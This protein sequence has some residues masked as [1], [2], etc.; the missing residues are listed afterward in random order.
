[1][2]CNLDRPLFEFRY[3]RAGRLLSATL[4]SWCV[5]STWSIQ[6]LWWHQSSFPRV[7]AYHRLWN[8]HWRIRGSSLLCLPG[9]SFPRHLNGSPGA[10]CA[11][12]RWSTV[13]CR[14]SSTTSSS[15]YSGA[16]AVRGPADCRKGDDG[17]LSCS[18]SKSRQHVYPTANTFPAAATATAVAGSATQAEHACCP[19]AFAA[20]TTVSH[21]T[22][23][24]TASISW[25]PILW[26]GEHHWCPNAPF[27]Q[28]SF[29]IVK[30]VKPVIFLSRPFVYVMRLS[31]LRSGHEVPC[32]AWLCG[33]LWSGYCLNPSILEEAPPVL[34]GHDL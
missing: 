17:H 10:F 22:I 6:L 7:P 34:V 8:E 2:E 32:A 19:T 21:S 18:S 16:S 29:P 15:S 28:S 25:W 31:I 9:L 26:L 3:K 27:Y 1:M 30:R 23:H 24:K 12:P 33:E 4:P 14:P 5:A 20:A 11:P 13:G